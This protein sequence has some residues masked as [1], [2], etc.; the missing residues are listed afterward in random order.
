M[1]DENMFVHWGSSTFL[2]KNPFE[3]LMEVWDVFPASLN[4]VIHFRVFLNPKLRV[5]DL[6]RKEN[7]EINRYLCMPLVNKALLKKKWKKEEQ[8]EERRHIEKKLEEK[9]WKWEESV[10]KWREV[11]IAF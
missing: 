11:K 1:W 3:N 4:V 6:S 2:I 8:L 9:K 10:R 5:S 7:N